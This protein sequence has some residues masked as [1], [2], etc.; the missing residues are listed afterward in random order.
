M[1]NAQ[2]EEHFDLDFIY[3]SILYVMIGLRG[4]PNIDA[5]TS[6]RSS[7][8]ILN[9]LYVIRN[10]K[11]EMKYKKNNVSL[12]CERY[13]LFRFEAMGLNLQ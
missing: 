11:Y 13:H 3:F 9:I 2:L 4:A 8:F 10:M 12:Q 6:L 5:C 1:K 7:A